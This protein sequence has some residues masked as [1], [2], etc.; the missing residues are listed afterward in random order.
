MTSSY[1]SP[2][3]DRIDELW[4]QRS[5]LTPDHTDAREIITGAIDQIDE[6]KARVA[7]VDRS[8]DAVVVGERA[9]RSILLGFKAGD[10]QEWLVGDSR[11]HDRA[12]R[13]TRFYAVPV[14]LGALAR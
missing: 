6:G 13:T 14:V 9:T 10:M 5:E 12:P 8:T 11:P 1:T 3:P 7:F 4:E 2:L